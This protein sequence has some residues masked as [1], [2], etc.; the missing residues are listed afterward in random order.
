MEEFFMVLDVRVFSRVVLT[1]VLSAALFAFLVSFDG[2]LISMFLAG[3]HAQTLPVRIWNSLNLQVEP[4]IAAVSGLLIG[5][6]TLILSIEAVL[7][8]RRGQPRGRG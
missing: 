4:T 5:V 2:L 6:T 1:G 7:R 8:P 3:V